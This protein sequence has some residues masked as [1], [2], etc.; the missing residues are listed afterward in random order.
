MLKI[1]E[2]FDDE[3]YVDDFG[4]LSAEAYATALTENHI[5][6]FKVYSSMTHI[7]TMFTNE[8]EHY[9][10]KCIPDIK[11]YILNDNDEYEADEYINFCNRND[12]DIVDDEN[13]DLMYV[14]SD[15]TYIAEIND[16]FYVVDVIDSIKIRW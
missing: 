14:E 16:K 4:K 11:K 9:L 13:G 12:I 15:D 2:N 1:I 6:G 5:F 10:R 8:R 7:T 3:L